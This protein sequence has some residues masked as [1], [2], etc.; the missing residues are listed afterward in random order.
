MSQFQIF[1][2]LDAF[3]EFG[4]E[5]L[6]VNQMFN[7][8]IIILRDLFKSLQ[9]FRFVY[10]EAWPQLVDDTDLKGK[11]LIFLLAKSQ[12]INN[13]IANLHEEVHLLELFFG[14]DYFSFVWPVDTA[15][16]LVHELD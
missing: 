8:L 10:E 12:D 5:A 7:I 6:K 2:L 1:T 9:N 11:H 13:C 16:I 15:Q 3:E 4:L 14:F